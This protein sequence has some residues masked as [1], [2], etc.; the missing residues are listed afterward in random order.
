[1]QHGKGRTMARLAV[2]T[3]AEPPLSPARERLRQLNAPVREAQAEL[4]EA[5]QAEQRLV[6]VIAAHD[7]A[8]A[9]LVALRGDDDAAL[10]A[11]LAEGTSGPRPGPSGW[12]LLS[13]GAM[14]GLKPA[15][16]MTVGQRSGCSERLPRT[17]LLSW[18]S[19]VNWQN[20][21]KGGRAMKPVT[22][23]QLQRDIERLM[24]Q[25]REIEA[26]RQLE[27]LAAAEIMPGQRG[28]GR[29]YDD[30]DRFIKIGTN[31]TST[32]SAPITSI[33]RLS[34]GWLVTA[35]ARVA[36][37]L[38]KGLRRL[39]KLA[40]GQMH[41]SE[42]PL[43]GHVVAVKVDEAGVAKITCKISNES[44]AWKTVEG[45]YPMLSI[46]HIDDEVLEVNLIDGPPDDLAKR[47]GAPRVL[48]KLYDG[49]D[50]AMSKWTK[51]LRKMGLSQPARWLRLC[52]RRLSRNCR[53]VR[54][55]RWPTMVR[56][57]WH[58]EA[59]EKRTDSDRNAA[60]AKFGQ[61]CREM[62][63]RDDQRRAVAADRGPVGTVRWQT[64]TKSTSSARLARRMAQFTLL[65]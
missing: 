51:R 59:A 52:A 8:V 58:S 33:E 15:C 27:R 12:R 36:G 2:V 46:S 49:K 30:V 21:N 41:N 18:R 39:G 22:A 4:A 48:A 65:G 10:A 29:S 57:W 16:R 19:I 60:R 56:R 43:A 31:S 38:R 40:L 50:R 35:T 13:G 37:P 14:S 24:A 47:G 28:D 64:P 7:R 53:S 17:S 55:Q 25:I 61:G 20:A 23:Q 5:R 26:H 11:W 34:S 44:T 32:L 63:D 42:L 62:P 45:V 54:R 3:T 9:E 6:D 1:M